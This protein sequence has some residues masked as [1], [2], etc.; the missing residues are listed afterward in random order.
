[1]LGVT[2]P[3]FLHLILMDESCCQTAKRLQK[4]AA[5]QKCCGWGFL[6]GLLT[7][8]PA[9]LP[10]LELSYLWALLFALVLV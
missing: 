7:P 9:I 4:Q 5:T 1:M 3:L 10:C 2:F 6:C 8:F